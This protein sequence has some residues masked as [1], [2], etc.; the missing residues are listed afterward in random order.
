MK[1]LVLIFFILMF[2]KIK[3]YNENDLINF[4]FQINNNYLD[5]S[6]VINFNDD[7]YFEQ[8]SNRIIKRDGTVSRVDGIC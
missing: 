3:T 1:N 8:C 4:K 2:F 7:N 6:N 5:K